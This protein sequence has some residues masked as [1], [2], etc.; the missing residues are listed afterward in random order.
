MNYRIV[1][2]VLVIGLICGHEA[3]A[4]SGKGGTI[5]GAGSAE[6][7]RPPQFLR[8]Q[9]ELLAKGKDLKEALVKMK[10]RREVIKLVLGKLDALPDSVAFSDPALGSEK[11]D[12]QKQ[13]A[14]MVAQRL[15]P[16]AK[17]APKSK[18][19]TPTVVSVT[20]KFDIS[21]KAGSI[22]DLLIASQ[23]LQAKIKNA[24][25]AGMK[26]FEKLSPQEEELAEEMRASGMMQ[27]QEEVK[28][29]EPMFYF[30]GKIADA[31]SAKALAEAF[32]KAQQEAT[33][34]AKAA[35][36]DL[37]PL[38]H[39]E[40]QQQAG[41][42]E[43]YAYAARYNQYQYYGGR[44]PMPSAVAQPREAVSMRAGAVT[45]RVAVAAQFQVKSK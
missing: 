29:G 34:L 37:G 24:D 42:D 26:E 39:L 18:D 41:G 32:G 27:G 10:E 30:V 13:F 4:Q 28:R 8:V 7:K 15:R 22:E 3:R 1:L 16:G 40:T 17:P 35:G 43:D 5:A 19:A 9:V 11:T 31:E 20:L 21:L 44:M 38:Y 36:V 23:E 2:G 45:Y 6:V 12:Q 33:E 25:L 14:A